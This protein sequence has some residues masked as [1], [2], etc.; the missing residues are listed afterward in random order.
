MPSIMLGADTSRIGTV[1]LTNREAFG[2]FPPRGFAPLFLALRHP[3]LVACLAPGLRSEKMRHGPARPRAR[4]LPPLASAPL[5]I[6]TNVGVNNMAHAFRA[7]QGAS[8]RPR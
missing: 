4:D 2:T 3:G 6:V 8:F 7:M 1:V 5:L